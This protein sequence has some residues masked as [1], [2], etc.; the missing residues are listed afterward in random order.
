[1]DQD[2]FPTGR[3]IDLAIAA[4][5]RMYGCA[6]YLWLLPPLDRYSTFEPA[7][8]TDPFALKCRPYIPFM[9]FFERSQG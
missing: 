3:N 9:S 5:F 7:S 1:M 2:G 4:A 8:G 6:F